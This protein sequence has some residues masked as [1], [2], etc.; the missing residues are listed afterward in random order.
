MIPFTKI[1]RDTLIEAQG[2]GVA[3]LNRLKQAMGYWAPEVKESWFWY[4]HG[5]VL[6]YLDILNSNFQDNKAVRNI[7]TKFI[8]KHYKHKKTEV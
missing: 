2:V 4:G 8:Y 6:G 1:I 3:D 7:Y 5:G